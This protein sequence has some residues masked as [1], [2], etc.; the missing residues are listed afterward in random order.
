LPTKE[1]LSLSAALLEIADLRQRLAIARIIA[2]DL[3]AQMEAM[4]RLPPAHRLLAW[5]RVHDSIDRLKAIASAILER[6]AT[7]GQPNLPAADR[8]SVWQAM[9]AFRAQ[10]GSVWHSY[11]VTRQDLIVLRASVATQFE[12]EEQERE[13]EVQA[14]ID[15]VKSM[16]EETGAGMSTF[17]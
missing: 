12:A 16:N 8:A 6:R 3:I 13:S 7:L 2:G 11:E 14:L 17:Y 9:A 15:I 1:P 10:M 5:K 4:S